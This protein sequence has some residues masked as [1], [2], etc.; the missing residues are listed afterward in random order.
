[1]IPVGVAEFEVCFARQS[2]QR[3]F[4]EDGFDPEARD[5]VFKGAYHGIIAVVGI[6]VVRREFDVELLRGF[7][8]EVAQV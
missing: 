3:N 2:K 6:V 5:G 1:M 7:E 8:A 4:I